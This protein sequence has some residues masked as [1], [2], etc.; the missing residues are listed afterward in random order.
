MLN[1]SRASIQANVYQ[2]LAMA[3]RVCL[4]NRIEGDSKIYE[5]QMVSVRRPSTI[6]YLQ[7]SLVSRNFTTV[8]SI[9]TK[10]IGS[11]YELGEPSHFGATKGHVLRSNVI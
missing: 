3:T 4:A 6:V 1:V 9:V 11:H 8:S 5:I 7:D 10:L 2:V